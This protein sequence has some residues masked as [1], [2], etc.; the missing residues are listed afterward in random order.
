M[1][2]YEITCVTL[3]EGGTGHEHI[4]HIGNLRGK[5]Q[6]DLDTA[7]SR[8]HQQLELFYTVDRHTGEHQY[9][10]IVREDGKRPHLRVRA[11]GRWKD[12]LLEL[13]PC[14][15]HCALL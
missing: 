14:N 4:T 12:A 13:P 9:L 2:E 11:G 7:I 15:E 1:K 8:I 3:A 6:L 5:W 10:R